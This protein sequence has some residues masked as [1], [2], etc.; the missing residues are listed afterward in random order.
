M[1]V[2]FR[3]CRKR[4]GYVRLR[5]RW[6][7]HLRLFWGVLIGHHCCI[8]LTSRFNVPVGHRGDVPLRRL[9]DVPSRRRWVFHL[10][11]ICSITGTYRDTSLRRRH[12]VLM[13]VGLILRNIMESLFY[14]IAAK[15]ISSLFISAHI[16]QINISHR[17]SVLF[18]SISKE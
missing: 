6:V 13:P 5:R 14:C 2:L 8:F 3:T 17:N 11:P 1:G 18:K 7:F 4:R 10:V 9:G 15:D 12:D 16:M